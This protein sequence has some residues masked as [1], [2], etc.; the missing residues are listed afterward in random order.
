MKNGNLAVVWVPT[1]RRCEC[2]PLLGG[3]LGNNTPA[4]VIT[5]PAGDFTQ[6]EQRTALAALISYGII[7]RQARI[8]VA[9]SFLVS[10]SQ[11]ISSKLHRSLP[12]MACGCVAATS[13][14]KSAKSGRS[15]AASDTDA[16]SKAQITQKENE[17]MR[18]LI[19][20]RG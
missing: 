6:C 11:E 16:G 10:I 14:R 9:I 12:I 1:F 18:L 20:W 7:W 8:C 2:T 4:S 17:Q 19:L 13:S 5:F 3:I 15:D